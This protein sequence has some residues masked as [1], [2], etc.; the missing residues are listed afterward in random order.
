MVGH[1]ILSNE[2]SPGAATA[3]MP[4]PVVAL[5]STRPSAATQGER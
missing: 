5:P 4:G 3:P 2:G 1:V